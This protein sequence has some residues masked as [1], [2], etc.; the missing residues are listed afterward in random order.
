MSAYTSDLLSSVL[1][2]EVV[3]EMFE[4]VRT[5]RIG[6]LSVATMGGAGIRPEAG[7]KF[8]WLEGTVSAQGSTA[9]SAATDTDT[10]ITVADGSVFRAGTAFTPVGSD[11]QIL[12]TAVS[13]N[14]LTVVRGFGDTTAEAIAADASL[15]VDSVGREENS[16]A[17]TDNIWQ[18][19]MVYNYFQTMDT[20]I[21]FSRRALATL[22]YGNTNDVTFQIQER[23]RQLAIQMNRTLIRGR[24][25][26]A[27]ISGNTV[28]YTGGMAFYNDQ[29]GAIKEDA[30][31]A[32]LTLDLIN[33]LNQEIVSRGGTTNTIA[34]GIAKARELSAL[35]AQNYQSQRLADWTADEGAIMRLPSDLP[36]VGNVNQIVVDTNIADDE[37]YIFDSSKLIVQHMDSGNAA[38]SG[39]WRTL[40][41][42]QKGQDGITT[43]I[44]GDYGM[45]IRDSKSHLARLHNLA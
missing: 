9:A 17:A 38:E 4:I 12:V 32:A 24:R 40:D 14:D 30:S 41:A 21:E 31:A 39:L 5:N 37:L 33:D 28:S 42:T 43:R 11:E 15:V 18:P 13:G 34:V 1:N 22:Q 25:A 3:N 2:A 35:V 26:E 7:S 8:S 45:E 10:T 27:T 44:I 6:V 36:L 20:A 23:I 16:L 19:D 29:T